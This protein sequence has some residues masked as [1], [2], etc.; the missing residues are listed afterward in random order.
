MLSI[1]SV[2]LFALGLTAYFGVVQ[3]TTLFLLLAACS[4]I[5]TGLVW[6]VS[7]VMVVERRL[8]RTS[9]AAAVEKD[10]DRLLDRLNTVVELDQR[11]TNDPS[12]SMYRDAIENQAAG[13]VPKLRTANPLKKRSVTAHLLIMLL[14]GVLAINFYI[15]A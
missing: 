3:S 13:M 10:N 9:L 2:L 14:L 12:A 8:D 1:L 15:S 11:M 7:V 4:C 6:L 5:G